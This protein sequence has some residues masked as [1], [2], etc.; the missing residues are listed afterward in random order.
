MDIN[1]KPGENK[2]NCVYWSSTKMVYSFG[3]GNKRLKQGFIRGFAL[4]A[5]WT[6]IFFRSHNEN[7]FFNSSK[8]I[9]TVQ[10]KTKRKGR[11][12]TMHIT[13]EKSFWFLILQTFFFPFK[14][15]VLKVV[16]SKRNIQQK[17]RKTNSCCTRVS[18]SSENINYFTA[19]GLSLEWNVDHV[20]RL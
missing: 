5:Q 16:E 1:Y 9:F 14:K 6:L 4:P 7:E 11:K 15:H 8:Q 20:A 18:Q 10:N 13:G 12:K 19:A 2:Q 3:S 17:I